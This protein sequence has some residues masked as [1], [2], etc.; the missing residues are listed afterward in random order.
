VLKPAKDRFF[1][2]DAYFITLYP[3]INGLFHMHE[4]IWFFHETTIE[5]TNPEVRTAEG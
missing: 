1:A 2:D 4:W 3:M 5:S